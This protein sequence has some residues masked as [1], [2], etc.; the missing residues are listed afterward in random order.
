MGG[1]MKCF[2]KKLLGHEIFRS[3][4]SWAR[5]FFFEKFVKPSGPSSFILNVRFL[6]VGMRKYKSII[7]KSK[8]KHDKT[9][10][11]EIFKLNSIK[12]LISKALIDSKISYDEFVLIN[13]ST[14]RE[15]QEDVKT[16]NGRIIYQN[17]HCV[18]ARNQNLLKSRNLE[19]Y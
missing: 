5:K 8:N 13:E 6:T 12:V 16:K 9:L 1:A 15:N 4:V 19:D 17:V 7:K 14:E 11:L 2:L 10:S 3:M 18:I